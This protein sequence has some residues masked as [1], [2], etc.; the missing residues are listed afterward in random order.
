MTRKH[1]KAMA[2]NIKRQL[3]EDP[4]LRE[5]LRYT[6]K[7][8]AELAASTNPRFNHSKFYRACGLE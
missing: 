3:D 4:K 2:D 8:F 1:F 6:A 7:A 5:P